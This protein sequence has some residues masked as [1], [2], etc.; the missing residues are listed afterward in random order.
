[1]AIKDKDGKVYKLRGPNPIM[2]E[3]SEWD[4]SY[5][6]LIN[7]DW[8]SEVIADEQN[9]IKETEKHVINIRDELGLFDNPQTKVVS[10]SQ[11]IKEIN[12][13]PEETPLP[14]FVGLEKSQVEKKA[15]PEEPV[16]FN[17][18]VRTARILKERGVEFYCA[19]AIGKKKHT[20]SLY[21]DS[22][23]TTIY[24]DQFIFDGIIID[25]S[26]LQLQ[27]WCIKP[28]AKDS[29]IY[30]KIKEGGERWWRVSQVEPK[31]GGYLCLCIISDVNPDFS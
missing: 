5:V 13:K 19:P 31:T 12:E 10:A 16:V 1:M 9:P 2:K 27:F 15:E 6:K 4:Q 22:Y 21:D 20:D 26:D 30:R 8:K 7:L 24:G 18:D 29:V 17:V 14:Q 23:E 3:Q 11:F 28:L 25:Q